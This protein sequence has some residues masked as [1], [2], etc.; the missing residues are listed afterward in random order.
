MTITEIANSLGVGRSTAADY[1]NHPRTGETYRKRRR[2]F[3]KCPNY[4]CNREMSYGAN[5][6]GH[7]RKEGRY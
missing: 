1:I 2:Q 4:G 6:C 7:C 3:D 5:Q